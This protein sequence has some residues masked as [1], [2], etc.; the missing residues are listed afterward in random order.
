MPSGWAAGK[1]GGEMLDGISRRGN[2]T[3]QIP[4]ARSSPPEAVGVTNGL[5]PAAL[6][7]KEKRV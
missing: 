6:F 2:R 5:N 1:F 3:K 7:G 4:P